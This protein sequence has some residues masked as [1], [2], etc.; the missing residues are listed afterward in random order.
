MRQPKMTAADHLNTFSITI[1]EARTFIVTHIN[2][3][4][5][6]LQT[7]LAYGVTNQMLAEIYGGVSKQDVI[8]FFRN[9]GLSSLELDATQVNPEKFSTQDLDVDAASIQSLNSPNVISLASGDYWSVTNLT[10]S[11]NTSFPNYYYSELSSSYLSSGPQGGWEALSG[12]AQIASKQ[13][14]N[15]VSNLTLLT[16]TEVSSTQGDI[17]FNSLTLPNS[18]DGFAYYPSSQPIGG[19]IFLNNKYQ[20]ED[21]YKQGGTAYN[22]LTH[23]LGHALGLKH[24]FEN[25]NPLSSNFENSDYSIMSYTDVRELVPIFSYDSSTFR[26]NVSYSQE[27]LKDSFSVL[28]VAALQAIYGVNSSYATGNDTYTLSFEQKKYLTIWD[29]GGIDTIN[30]ADTIGNSSIDLRPGQLS[31]IDVRSINQQIS[32]TLDWLNNQNAPDYSDFVNEV[33]NDNASSIYTGENNLTIAFGVWIENITTGSGNDVVRDN[34][35]DNIINTGAG[36]DIIQLYDGGY[37]R[38]NGGDGIDSIYLDEPLSSVSYTQSNSGYT[39][40]GDNFS[41][42]IIGIETL[43]FSDNSSVTLV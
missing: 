42:E 6:I 43:V 26:I 5:F 13:V 21:D 31:S 17:N 30:V 25:P 3:P 1:E 35:V 39:L 41:A 22:T 28:D 20:T 10:Y 36:N 4:S 33:F 14:L 7:S 9:S 27:A 18:T 8:D 29:A 38:V 24:S 15:D 37:D 19:E 23:E 32:D 11:F 16:F 34:A 2:N 40:V 12:A